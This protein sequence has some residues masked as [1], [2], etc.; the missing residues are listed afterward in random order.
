[1][2]E[3][4]LVTIVTVT[5]NRAGRLRDAIESVLALEFKDWEYLLIDDGSDDETAAVMRNYQ[6]K[7]PFI[8]TISRPQK[9]LPRS[10][11]EAVPLA[12]G[13]YLAFLDD[14]DLFLSLRF[15]RHISF[16]EE[17][18]WIALVYSRVDMRGKYGQL[19][20]IYPQEPVLDFAGLL[21]D[22]RIQIHAA[23]LRTSCVRE[24]G[25]FDGSLEGCDDYD[26]WL[27]IAKNYPIAFIPE[28]VGCYIW[29]DGNLS[30]N[31]GRSYRA[32]MSIFSKNARLSLNFRERRILLARCFQLNQQLF[33]NKGG[34][35][36]TELGS[37]TLAVCTRSRSPMLGDTLRALAGQ[38]LPDGVRVEILVVDNKSTDDT[39]Q[40]V[41][42]FSRE[43]PVPISYFF[44]G[45]GG[46]SAAR[47]RVLEE[48]TGELVVF[49]D[50]DVIPMPDWLFELWTNYRSS[51]ASVLGGPIMPLW[52]T[53]PPAFIAESPMALSRL[54]LLD[55]GK[56]PIL[57]RDFDGDMIYGANMAIARR[58]ALECGSFRPD[59]DTENLKRGG[60]TEMIFR[61]ASHGATIAYLPSAAVYHRIPS[62]RM[63]VRYL[64]GVSY[65]GG[66]A[67]ARL[68]GRSY[69]FSF[70]TMLKT[71]FSAFSIFSPRNRAAFEARLLF[72]EQCGY[73]MES[74]LIFLNK[75]IHH[76]S[77][78][79]FRN[80]A[81][82]QV[83]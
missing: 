74:A 49:T 51:G 25:G 56:I 48:A 44:Q 41:E 50:D 32:V 20:E 8:R 24:L 53:E 14:D 75:K 60:D 59:L 19:S 70:S 3:Q 35:V 34:E 66:K 67:K 27:R 82:V 46:L 6:Q 61:L 83:Q 37:V 21:E 7:F 31:Q 5:C 65:H 36:S 69:N 1:M 38:R 15:C 62:A 43:S 64:C 39:C 58:A 23:T 77:R 18:P 9:G 76:Y 78:N 57:A 72:S 16:M 10:R 13:K 22:N 42:N 80:S 73:V 79:T 54:A 26:L 68:F 71:G 30:L 63:S 4:P 45:A 52:E 40:V 47:N 17:N 55:R 2:S 11:S 81:K 12:R 33:K 28:T 29:H